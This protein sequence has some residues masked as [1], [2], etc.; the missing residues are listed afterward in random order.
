MCG[1]MTLHT[2]V[3]II[4]AGFTGLSVAAALKRSGVHNFVVLDRRS[5]ASSEEWRGDT[6]RLFALAKHLHS[7]HEAAALAYDAADER[8]TI[9]VAGGEDLS[10]RS[11]VL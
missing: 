11:V 3:A 2:D 6:V 5:A 4:G 10:V 9:K 7:G 8:W 1:D